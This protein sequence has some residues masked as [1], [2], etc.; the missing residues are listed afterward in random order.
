MIRRQF[1]SACLLTPLFACGVT[2][3]HAQNSN[4]PLSGTVTK[5]SEA[6]GTI[7][8]DD[9]PYKIRSSVKMVELSGEPRDKL[10]KDELTEGTYIEFNANNDEPTKR[11]TVMAIP[12]F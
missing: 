3:A 10:K 2:V 5:I 4:L 9:T 7:F 12:N 11:I 1:I 6:S 8:V